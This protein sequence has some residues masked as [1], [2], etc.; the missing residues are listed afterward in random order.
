VQQEL[1]DLLVKQEPL[2]VLEPLDLLVQAEQMVLLAPLVL[3]AIQ[4]LILL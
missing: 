3:L 1:L 4:V 2:E